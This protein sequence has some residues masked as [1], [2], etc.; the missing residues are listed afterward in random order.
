MSASDKKKLRKEQNAAA[1]TE[2]Q[3][4]E[5]K[6]AKKL[7]T[8]TIT[9]AVVMILVVAII[10]GV[11]LR[12]PVA[13]IIDRNTDAITVGNHTLSTNELSYFYVDAINNFTSQFD[14]Y[15]SYAALYMQMM[16]LDPSKPLDKQV[17]DQ[18]TQQTWAD[19]FINAA[20]NNAKWTYA[21]YDAAMKAGFTLSQEDLT[22]MGN[23]EATLEFYAQYTGYSSVNGYLRSLYGDGANLKTY[24]DYYKLT[25]IASKFA[26]N[27]R[28]SLKY[29]DD[30]YRE[31]E[32]DKLFEYNSYNYGLYR[33][34]ASAYKTFLK[35]GTVTKD[36]NGKETTVYTEADEAKALEAALADA[37]ALVAEGITDLDKL[38]EAINKLAI[39]LPKKEDKDTKT[40]D[41]NTGDENTGDESTGDE[42]TDEK[43]KDEPETE[44]DYAIKA[45]EGKNVLYSKLKSN[46]NEDVQK[47][48]SD[49]ARKAGDVTYIEIS[50]GEGDDKVVTGYYVVMYLGVNNNT[51][52]SVDVQHILVK[53]KG[54]TKNPTTGKTEYSDTEKKTA[55]EAAQKILGEFLD[56]KNITSEAFGTL[57]KS[58]SEDTG[59]KSN[60][61]L[62]SGIN[63]DAGYV[64]AFTDW[65]LA[66]HKVGDTGIIETEYGYHVMFY[67]GTSDLAYRDSLINNDL[68]DRDYDAWEDTITKDVVVTDINLNGL[69][70]DFVISG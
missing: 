44:K 55:K 36:E 7:K 70:R 66:E 34:S 46:A 33:I 13:G 27:Y 43:P 14:S 64:T 59:S 42:N 18:T 30:D 52:H 51:Y 24:Q 28:D 45:T 6:E 41:E 29:T 57:A 17:A 22:A 65:A 19:Y 61:G 9:F 31:F 12:T 23:L 62:I 49:S 50:T 67:K 37:K 48:L 4:K 15:G 2:K 63:Y 16:G 3:Q 21:M 5:A 58:K 1:M 40:G 69:K 56:G 25:T 8:Y 11:T 20:K 32:K 53:F 68:V 39:N 47:W 35:L 60:G 26:S 10:L 38:N 54:G